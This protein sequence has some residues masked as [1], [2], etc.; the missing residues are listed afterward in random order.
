MFDES[1]VKSALNNNDN[2]ISKE[3]TLAEIFRYIERFNDN[4]EE[5]DHNIKD[6]NLLKKLFWEFGETISEEFV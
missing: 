2:S 5:L 3:E 1:I 4:Y 6:K